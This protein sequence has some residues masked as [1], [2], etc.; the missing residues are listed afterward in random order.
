MKKISN[1][2]RL[3]K[4]RAI[5][6]KQIAYIDFD[7]KEALVTWEEVFLDED[8]NPILDDTVSNRTIQSHISNA[9]KVNEQG[10]VIDSDNFTE[11]DS[12]QLAEAQEQGFPEFDFYVSQVLNMEA[13]EQAIEVLDQMKRF[14]RR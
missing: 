3:D 2:P 10:I 4:P 6:L 11:L 13:I 14:D 7:I 5:R 8:D 12:D 9:N 1:H